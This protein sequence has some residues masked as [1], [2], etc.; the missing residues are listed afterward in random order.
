MP[1]DNI[2]RSIKRASGEGMSDNM[3]KLPMKVTV[4]QELQS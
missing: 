2:Q 4:L 3:E 1:N